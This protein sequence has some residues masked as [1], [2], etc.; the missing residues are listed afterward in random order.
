MSQDFIRFA[1]MGADNE[2]RWA[3]GRPDCPIR[4]DGIPDGLQGAD[5]E[6]SYEQNVGQAGE[7]FKG[8]IDKRNTIA[9][10][11]RVGDGTTVG[12]RHR[13]LHSRWR[14]SLGRG[15]TQST[16]I[17]VSK[18]SGYRWK[19]TRLQSAIQ[20]KGPRRTMPGE[21]GI[22]WEDIV[23]ASD[24]SFWTLPDIQ[25]EWSARDAHLA[26]LHNPGD[27]HAWVRYTLTGP[28][29]NYIIGIGGDQ[30][31]LGPVPDGGFI[32][33]DTDPASPTAVNELG[34]DLYEREYAD[35]PFA[36]ILGGLRQGE[37]PGPVKPMVFREAL[38]A[39]GSDTHVETPLGI[40][41]INAGPDAMVYAE[42]TPR[43]ERAW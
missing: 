28:C 7:D 14:R 13:M 33:V 35:F 25:R 17:V 29:D 38:P 22:G 1:L 41:A 16:F 19:K 39:G 42:I 30:V 3:F 9:M 6:L 20:A 31:N 37:L 21:L 40:T 27:Q 4:M 8:R 43:S 11:V 10:R 26:A 15:T 23:L 36:G 5:F 32:F 2:T 34:E 24:E 18:E 12:P